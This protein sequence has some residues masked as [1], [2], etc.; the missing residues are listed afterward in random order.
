MK[1]TQMARIRL[2]QR[3]SFS[4]DALDH[5]TFNGVVESI[6]P[7]TGSEFS[8]ISSDNATGNFVKI[9]QRIL[10]RV[11]IDH[12]NALYRLLRPGMSVEVDIDTDSSPAVQERAQVDP[13]TTPASPDG[14]STAPDSTPAVSGAAEGV[15]H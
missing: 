4:V 12:D 7:A 10:V 3:A 2:G 11:H 15:K 9:A 14:A 1:E 5:A 8:A 13:D 6:S